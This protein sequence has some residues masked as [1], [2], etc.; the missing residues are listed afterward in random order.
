MNYWRVC[1][2]ARHRLDQYLSRAKKK[3]KKKR[4]YFHKETC[5]IS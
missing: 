2:Y 3:K 1:V 5:S 4:S